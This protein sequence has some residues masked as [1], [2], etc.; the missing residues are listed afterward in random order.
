MRTCFNHKWE[1]VQEQ[2][3]PCEGCKRASPKQ[4]M[5][6]GLVF[7]LE[8]SNLSAKFIL[9][10]FNGRNCLS[11]VNETINRLMKAHPCDMYLFY[12]F[13][14]CICICFRYCYFNIHHTTHETNPPPPRFG[15]ITDLEPPLLGFSG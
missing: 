11:K 6:P 5:Y 2:E 12:A 8:Y 4:V 15:K 1:Y 3:Y 7:T 10:K 13:L 14:L 9:I